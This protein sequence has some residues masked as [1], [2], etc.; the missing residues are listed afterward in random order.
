MVLRR[1]QVGRLPKLD[2]SKSSKDDETRQP[3]TN[4]ECTSYYLTASAYSFD[5]YDL[6]SCR[7]SESSAVKFVFLSLLLLGLDK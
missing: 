3:H 2:Q 5:V 7:T 1:L 6:S 4:N